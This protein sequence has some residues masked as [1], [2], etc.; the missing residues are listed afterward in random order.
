M[1]ILVFS[2]AYND[3]FSIK[4]LSSEEGGSGSH[5]NSFLPNHVTSGS[6]TVG[7]STG[8]SA[9]SEQVKS[10]HFVRPD[11]KQMQHFKPSTVSGMII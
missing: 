8:G 6:G 3:N 7:M 2:S 9:N 4:V 11:V 1:F 10:S 5:A